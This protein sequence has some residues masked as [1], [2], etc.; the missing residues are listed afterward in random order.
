[1]D[2]RKDRAMVTVFKPSSQTHPVLPQALHPFPQRFLG[3][4]KVVNVPQDVE[5]TSTCPSASPH[6]PLHAFR[7]RKYGQWQ[8]Q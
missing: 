4:L 5:G 8:G 2:E 1:M 6:E 7:R 3:S